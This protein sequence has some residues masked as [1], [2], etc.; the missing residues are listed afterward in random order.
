MCP[1][2]TRLLGFVTTESGL[3]KA[4]KPLQTRRRITAIIIIIIRPRTKESLCNTDDFLTFSTPYPHNLILYAPLDITH[5][6]SVC[7]CVFTPTAPF[8]SL[9]FSH[10]LYLSPCVYICLP[11][12][13]SIYIFCLFRHES[14]THAAQRF[15]IFL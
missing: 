3:P 10:T 14:N 12:P 8:L 5:R 15:L 7:V 9:S 4:R 2:H 1:N 6:L 11:P 13:T